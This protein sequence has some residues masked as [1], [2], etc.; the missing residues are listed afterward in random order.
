M[1]E[2]ILN[3]KFKY[4]Y[5]YGSL[6]LIVI[7]VIVY[8]LQRAFPQLT[9]YLGM[10]PALIIQKHYFWQFFTYMFAHGS[11]SHLIS[12]MISLLIFSFMLEKAIGTKEYFLYYFVCGTLAGIASFFVYWI[13]KSYF[14]VLLG[15]SGAIYAIMLLFAVVF[16][17]SRIYV[18][19]L[20]PIRA[21]LL[22]LIYFIIEFFSQFARDGV[23]H[24]TH[25]F[26]I[27]F[28]YL[29]IWIR[30]K[31]NPIKAVFGRRT[32]VH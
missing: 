25:L 18:F 10:M 21:P 9:Y 27:L 11:L 26:G 17:N 7:N 13:S 28:G 23:A 3:R 29:Y 4:S 5:N 8:M 1:G 22:V 2:S 6:I 31:I 19:W 20:I 24:T 30:M 14:T 32:I 12:N 15:A 16:P